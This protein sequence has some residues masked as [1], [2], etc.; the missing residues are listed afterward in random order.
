VNSVVVAFV[1]AKNSYD[2]RDVALRA[3][4]RHCHVY[5]ELHEPRD[6][7][8]GVGGAGEPHEIFDAQ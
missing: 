8:P 7:T 4:G 1:D 3:V 2:L 6:Q 5:D